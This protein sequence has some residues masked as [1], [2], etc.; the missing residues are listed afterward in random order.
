MRQLPNRNAT[1]STDA[2]YR[3]GYGS[4]P[5]STHFATGK[6]VPQPADT[7]PSRNGMP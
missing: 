1:G 7:L 3:V 6:S 4:Q 5:A 2:T